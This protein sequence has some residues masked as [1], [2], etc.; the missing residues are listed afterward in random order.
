MIACNGTDNILRWDGTTLD[1]PNTFTGVNENTLIQVITYKNSL[2]F[3]QKNSTSIWYNSVNTIA[4][5]L[6]QFDVGSVL[7]RG[8][9]IKFIQ[10]WGKNTVNSNTDL[11]VIVSDTGEVLIY[12]GDAPSS[13]AWALVAHFYLASPL[14]DRAYIK[15][16]SDLWIV[17]TLGVYAVSQL[18]AGADPTGQTTVV[19]DLIKPTFN[20]SASL[21][22]ANFGWQ[23]QVY[24][25]GKYAFIN[26][27]V[28]ENV[29]TYQYVVNL[30]TGAWCRFI[31]WNANCWSTFA[32]NLY[33]G[34]SGNTI[35]QA[36]TGQTDNGIPISIVCKQAF[37]GFENEMLK[38]SFKRLKPTFAA[39]QGSTLSIDVDIDFGTRNDLQQITFTGTSTPWGSAW[40][41]PWDAG[42]IISNDWYGLTG[43][44]TF[45]SVRYEANLS[46]VTL[47]HISSVIVYEEG[48]LI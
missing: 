24:H 46:N 14:S 39:T 37:V 27:P 41:S 44:G 36:D 32:D 11:L 21:Y 5:A 29:Q 26:I 42:V 6:R 43:Q 4:G 3:V 16:D 28:A 2:Y 33:F 40:G 22:S 48:A 9:K 1:Q 23:G 12:D 8:G 38:K 17:T 20:S 18:V 45:A 25:K 15:V 31:G 35:C 19:D 13:T 34:F 7:Q 47:Q 30:I 10:S